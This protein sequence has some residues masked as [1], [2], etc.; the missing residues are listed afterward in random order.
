[1]IRGKSRLLGWLKFCCG[2]L[3]LCALLLLIVQSPLPGGIAGEVVRNNHA[4]QIDA[5][6]LFYSEVDGIFEMQR[7]VLAMR[8]ESK[9]RCGDQHP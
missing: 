3:L 2:L 1:M 8:A 5:S 9:S 6:P 7:N 4:L